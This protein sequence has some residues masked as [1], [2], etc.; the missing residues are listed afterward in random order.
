MPAQ[1]RTG[2]I[3]F[4]ERVLLMLGG[5][6][7]PHF[8]KIRLA[9]QRIP[10]STPSFFQKFEWCVAVAASPLPPPARFLA[11]RRWQLARNASGLLTGGSSTMSHSW[12]TAVCQA[13]SAAS[14]NRRSHLT[15]LSSSS[16]REAETYRGA[17]SRIEGA[18]LQCRAPLDDGVIEQ[19]EHQ[20]EGRQFLF[21]DGAVIVAFE[22]FGDDGVDLALHRQQFLVGFRGAH[23]GNHGQ[24]SV[25]MADIFLPFV[26]IQ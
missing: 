12:P 24:D 15:K 19:F 4:T 21:L 26:P 5:R 13:P 17:P 6:A 11:W 9:F 14:A 22:R 3:S 23:P 10:K 1:I 7:F 18:C 16:R 25:A 8:P 2:R 20:A